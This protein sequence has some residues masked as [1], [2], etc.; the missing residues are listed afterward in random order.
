LLMLE[1]TRTKT[2]LNNDTDSKSWR[3]SFRG[4]GINLS[5]VLK[6]TGTGEDTASYR[7]HILIKRNAH[8]KRFAVEG[9]CGA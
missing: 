9:G 7:G 3:E 4:Q 5:L 8:E 2:E 1:S 6:K